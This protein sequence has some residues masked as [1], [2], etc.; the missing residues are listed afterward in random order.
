MTPIVAFSLELEVERRLDRG[1]VA[2]RGALCLMNSYT[3]L[4]T[5]AGIG[6]AQQGNE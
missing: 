6:T 3:S 2:N 4:P 5:N 1:A